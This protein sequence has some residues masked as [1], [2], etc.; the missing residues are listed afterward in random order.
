MLINNIHSVSTR[1]NL[2]SYLINHLSEASSCRFYVKEHILFLPS[3]HIWES[4]GKNCSALY[5]EC[6][7]LPIED[8]IF[9][10]SA[11]TPLIF[12]VLTTMTLSSHLADLFPS[13]AFEF[14]HFLLW[15]CPSSTSL[16]Q[17]DSESLHL[18][19]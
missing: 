7:S 19:V 2:F 4:C 8:L 12:C 1:Q 14:A 17:M 18:C 15:F 3:A 5:S 13:F 9:F 6:V 11:F 10:L 16:C